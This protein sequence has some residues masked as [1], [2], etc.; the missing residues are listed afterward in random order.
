[1]LIGAIIL[2][3]L[4]WRQTEQ[5]LFYTENMFQSDEIVMQIL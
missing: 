5:P 2:I 4:K 3:T 1:M